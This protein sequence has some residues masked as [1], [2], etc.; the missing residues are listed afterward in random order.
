M[1]IYHNEN[2]CNLLNVSVK[3]FVFYVEQF[4][5]NISSL[6]D[7]SPILTVKPGTRRDEINIPIPVMVMVD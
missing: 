5:T 4:L 3:S 7:K 2:D 6:K 1:E